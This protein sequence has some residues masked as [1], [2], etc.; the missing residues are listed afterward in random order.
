MVALVSPLAASVGLSGLRAPT[1]P[2]GSWGSLLTHY[3]ELRSS[4]KDNNHMRAAGGAAGG[5]SC[6]ERLCV[7]RGH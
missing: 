1:G 5:Y 6:K 4:I 3:V 2:L 7:A